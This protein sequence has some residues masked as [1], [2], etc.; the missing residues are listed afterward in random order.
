MVSDRA[1]PTRW[2]VCFVKPGFDAS[3]R[4]YSTSSD[5]RNDGFK[6]THKCE[7]PNDF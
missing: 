2:Q 3:F 7:H 5:T 6:V 1:I 4:D